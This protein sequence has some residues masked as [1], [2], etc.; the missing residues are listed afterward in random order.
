MVNVW[1]GKVSRIGGQDRVGSHRASKTF[2]PTCHIQLHS[3]LQP[4]DGIS[5]FLEWDASVLLDFRG[6]LGTWPQNFRAPRAECHP[7]PRLVAFV[8]GHFR[9]ATIQTFLS[10][11]LPVYRLDICL[12]PCLSRTQDWPLGAPGHAL[13]P[14]FSFLGLDLLLLSSIING[15]DCHLDYFIQG[16]HQV[17]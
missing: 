12:M 3:W 15:T 7:M 13:S 9:C 17:L 5:G 11:M 14:S 8:K 4:H 2:G 6:G 10:P 1:R 16:D